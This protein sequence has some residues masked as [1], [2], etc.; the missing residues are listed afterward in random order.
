MN[1]KQRRKTRA[2]V[3]EVVLEWQSEEKHWEFTRRLEHARGWLQWQTKRKNYTTSREG[4]YSQTFLFRS[5]GIAS[6]FAL[7][8]TR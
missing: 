4:Y 2:F 1:S 3:H 7:K 5:G 6:A 8:W